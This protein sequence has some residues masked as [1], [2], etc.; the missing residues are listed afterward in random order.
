MVRASDNTPTEIHKGAVYIR[1]DMATSHEEADNI[2]A[3]QAIMCATQQPG[4]VSVIADDTDVSCSFF[5]I[6]KRKGFTRAMFMTSPAQQRSTID[7]KA[8][9]EKHHAIVP[10]LLTVHALSGCDT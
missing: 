7:I 2:K 5:I 10:G 6:I 9:V 3:Q 1:Q 4:A 8:T